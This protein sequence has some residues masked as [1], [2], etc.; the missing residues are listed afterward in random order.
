[1][2]L[3]RAV[4]A[5]G[6][7]AVTSLPTDPDVD[8]VQGDDNVRRAAWMAL[9][10]LSPQATDIASDAQDVVTAMQNLGVSVPSTY[11]A[12]YSYAQAATTIEWV[13]VDN[14]DVPLSEPTW[15][16]LDFAENVGQRIKLTVHYKF[17]LNVP[18]LRSLP[19]FGQDDTVAGI[20]GKFLTLNASYI[21][22]LTH[23]RE[24]GVNNA[25]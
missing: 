15:Q 7:S 12:R 6:R 22:Q 10:P 24:A 5:A 23:G 3:E 4:M 14:N 8:Y 11:A 25:Q 16:P 2:G 19:G 17:Y 1:M 9:E 21:V 20:S 13:R 18:A